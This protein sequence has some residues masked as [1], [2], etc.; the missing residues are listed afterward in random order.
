MKKWE[1]S[2]CQEW[3]DE[4]SEYCGQCCSFKLRWWHEALGVFM[5]GVVLIV[6]GSLAL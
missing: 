3:T 6:L 5:I 4:D 2:Y 1:C